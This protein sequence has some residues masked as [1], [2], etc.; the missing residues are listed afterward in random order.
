M[1]ERAYFGS[2]ARQGAIRKIA[3]WAGVLHKLSSTS[4]DNSNGK[5]GKKSG[6]AEI[7]TLTYIPQS[8]LS[9]SVSVFAIASSATRSGAA[10][11][12][13]ELGSAIDIDAFTRWT[14]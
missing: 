2:I 12:V 7:D 6:L 8:I 11:E 3:R 10:R 9:V 14:F 1:D 5:R 13:L 4:F